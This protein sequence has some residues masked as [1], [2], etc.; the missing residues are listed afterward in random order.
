MQISSYIFITIHW[1]LKLDGEHNVTLT[2]PGAFPKQDDDYL[3]SSFRVKDWIGK[4]T[5]YINHFNVKATAQKVHH[6]LIQACSVPPVEP[7][8]V[9]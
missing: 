3:C 9:W 8:K 5:V 1:T 6:L 4:E 7:G 2:M